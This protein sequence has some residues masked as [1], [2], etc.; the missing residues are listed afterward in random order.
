MCRLEIIHEVLASICQKK[1]RSFIAG[2]GVTWGI[3]ILIL[4]LGVGQGFQNGVMNM[5]NIFTQKSMYIFG[6]Q[7]SIKHK[8]SQVGQQI[9]FDEQ[10]INSLKQQFPTI[11]A[12]SAEA[13]QQNVNARNRNKT[14]RTTLKGVETDYFRIKILKAKNNGRLF[15]QLDINRKRNVTIIGEGIEQTL[16]KSQNSVGKFLYINNS[17]YRIIGV[18]KNDNLLS[19]PERNSIYIPLTTFHQDFTKN[20]KIQQFCLTV[21]SKV[22]TLQFEKKLKNYIS[23]SKCFNNNDKQA[24]YISNI[25]SQ[26][27]AFENLFNGLN[28]MIWGVGAS[29]LLS[30]IIGICNIM[31]VVVK[32]RTNEIGIRKALGAK[33]SAI[34]A[35]IITESIIITLIAGLIGIILGTSSLFIIDYL[36]QNCTNNFILSKT[37]INLPI[38]I[39]ALVVLIISGIIAGLVPSLKAARVMPVEAIRYDTREN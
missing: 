25:E 13:V 30:G 3:F 38:I 22:N 35:I 36:I 14:T 20:K 2:F 39:I 23:H 32:E 29:I 8:T 19:I 1:I 24:L 6:G 21:E 5:F 31:L 18:L 9:L 12:I 28:I 17:Y 10:Y 15:N 34:I 33:P 11:K 7:T 4:L 16:F 27:T 37:S 26:T